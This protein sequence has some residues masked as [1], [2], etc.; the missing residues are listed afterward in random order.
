MSVFE[1][2]DHLGYACNDIH[3]A[4]ESIKKNYPVEQIS[5][6]VFDPYQNASLCY[7]HTKNGPNIE[8]ISGEAV[9]NILKKGMSLYHTCYEV[10]D[11]RSAITNV[12]NNGG[13]IIKEPYPA[14]LFNNRKV[15]FLETELGL[16]ELLETASVSNHNQTTLCIAGTFNTH[17]LFNG[18]EEVFKDLGLEFTVEEAQYNQ[19][20]QLLLD[21]SSIFY[22]NQSGY[23]I[24]YLRLEDWFRF[25]DF[26][27]SDIN[28][29]KNLLQN[30]TNDL[31]NGI[32]QL[33]STGNPL[34]LCLC[35]NT[36]ELP[37]ELQPLL[38]VFTSNIIEQLKSNKNVICN[39]E[40]LSLSP[41]NIYDRQ[42]DK[43]GH[44]PYN[45]ETNKAICLESCRTLHT[46][47]RRPYKVI[48]VDCDN[49]LWDGVCGEDGYNNIKLTAAN[50]YLQ[51]KLSILSKQGFLICLCSKNVESDVQ[52]VFEKREDFILQMSDL[53]ACKINWQRKSQNIRE[54]SNILNISLDDFIFIDDNPMEIAEVSTEL[55]QVLCLEFPRE[56]ALAHNLIKNAWC[57]DIHAN[58]DFDANRTKFYQDNAQR[59]QLKGSSDSFETFLSK[60]EIE[61][62]FSKIT[63]EDHPRISQLTQRTNQFNFTTIRRSINELEILLTD[64]SILGYKV[65]VK[66]RFGDYGLVGAVIIHNKNTNVFID[67]FLLSCRVLGKGIEHKLINEIGKV[68]IENNLQV[69]DIIFDKTQ[70]NQPA[71]DF[72]NNIPYIEKTNMDNGFSLKCDANALLLLKPAVSQVSKQESTL[73]VQ[74]YSTNNRI[75]D[76]AVVLKA[77][78]LYEPTTTNS[79]NISHELAYSLEEF[80]SFIMEIWSKFFKESLSIK[81][82][83][84]SLGGDS[85]LAI[86]VI[87]K[88]KQKYGLEISIETIFDNPRI[89][90][91]AK[92]IHTLS[93]NYKN[94]KNI[95]NIPKSTENQLSY[96]QEWLWLLDQYDNGNSWYYNMPYS[97]RLKGNINKVALEDAIKQLIMRHE[98]LRTNISYGS[99][100]YHCVLQHNINFSLEYCDAQ[101]DTEEQLKTRIDSAYRKPFNLS[102]DLLLRATLF[103][104]SDEDHVLVLVNHH[105]VSDGQSYK[106]I[107]N[108]ISEYYNAYIENRSPEL[109]DL[110]IQF[111]DYATWHRDFVNKATSK[112]LEF[113]KSYLNNLPQQEFPL[114]APRKSRNHDGCYHPLQINEKTATYLTAVA[115]QNKI[116]LFSILI[117][118][119]GILL[120]KQC[121]SQDIIITCP[122][123]GR[124]HHDS[125][126]LIGCFVNIVVFRLKIDLN[127][128]FSNNI[129]NNRDNIL[130]AL[131]NQDVPFDILLK[132]LKLPQEALDS[133][134]FQVM[135]ALQNT[136]NGM[137]NLQDIN[138]SLHQ[139]GYAA[140][141]L[142]LI[143]ELEPRDR[144]IVGGFY[145]NTNLFYESS[146]INYCNE[147]I[148][149]CEYANDFPSKPLFDFWNKTSL[150]N[151]ELSILNTP[152]NY[153]E[154][155]HNDIIEWFEAIA[156]KH[157]N[158]IALKSQLHTINYEQLDKKSNKLANYLLEKG[159]RADDIVAVKLPADI[160]SIISILAIMKLGA[161]YLPIDQSIP[162]EYFD[163][164]IQDSKCS[165][166]L[167]SEQYIADIVGEFSNYSAANLTVQK[168]N[169]A[170]IIYTSGTTG[171]PKGVKIPHVNIVQL[172]QSTQH[173]Y[174]FNCNDITILFHSIAFDFSVWEIWIALCY[175]GKLIIPT[176]QQTKSAQ[177][178]FE[179]VLQENVTV[180]NQTPTAFKQF[181]LYQENIAKVKTPHLRLVVFGGEK[182][183]PAD[184]KWFIDNNPDV[185]LYNMYGITETTVHVTIKH[186]DAKDISLQ[187]NI[188][189]PLPGR[190][191]YLLDQKGNNVTIGEIGEMYVAG[192]GLANG[193]LHLEQK[194]K[195]VFVPDLYTPQERMYK[196]GDL[197]RITNGEL[198]YLGRI[199][200]QVQLRGFR[201]ELSGIAAALNQHSGIKYSEVEV[202]NDSLAALI[203]PCRNAVLPYLSKTIEEDVNILPNG[204]PIIH[205]NKNETE[206]LYEEIFE[207]N[208]YLSEGIELDN[209]AC[210][211]D[212]GANI[213][214]FAIQAAMVSKNATVYAIEPV[215][216][217]HKVLNTNVSLY[218]LNIKTFNIGLSDTNCKKSINFYPKM[219][220]MSGSSGDHDEEK[221]LIRTHI[222][223]KLGKEYFNLNNDE[224]DEIINSYLQSNEIECD[225][226]TFDFF[227]D[228]N[229]IKKIDLLKIDVEKAE[230]QVLD[231]ISPKN[232]SI[233]QQCV[234]ELHDHEGSKNKILAI[235][236]ANNFICKVRQYHT[237]VDT[238]L[239]TIYA[240]KN[241]EFERTEHSKKHEFHYQWYSYDS[242]INDVRL[243]MKQNLPEYMQP[244]Y[245]KIV[246]QFPTTLTGKIDFS[247]FKSNEKN[248]PET[249]KDASL[250]NNEAEQVIIEVW[251]K[252]L[253]HKN[254]K[255]EDNFFDIGG[256]SLMTI[257]AYIKLRDM[258]PSDFRMIDFFS[259]PTARKLA[260]K[261]LSSKN[262]STPV[263][264]EPITTTDQVNCSDIA[265]IGYAGTFPNAENLNQYW[266]NLING[267]DCITHFSEDELLKYNVPPEYLQDSNYVKSCGKIDNIDLFDCDF[268]GVTPRE[269]SLMDPQHR[270]FLET[271]WKALES[272]GYAPEKTQQVIGI[273]AGMGNTNYLDALYKQHGLKHTYGRD[274][275]V[276]ITNHKD[277]LVNR[278]AYK[279]NLTGASININT[280]CSTSLV[281]CVKGCQSLL[282]NENDIVI[283]GGISLVLPEHYGYFH[284][285]ENVLSPDGV[286]RPFDNNA[287]G[288]VIGS[289]SG[290]VVLKK[291]SKAL[292]DGDSIKAVIKGYA[293]NND[294]NAKIG[295]TAPSVSGQSQCISKAQ[296][297]ANIT[298]KQLVYIEAHGTGTHLGD[299]IEI[300]SL[301]QVFEKDNLPANHCAIGSVK[302]NIGHADS[303]S[304]IAGLL[305]T[306]LMLEKKQIPPSIHFESANEQI[307]FST[308]PFYVNKEVMKLPG[309]TDIYAGVSSFGVG[310]ANAH[311]VLTAAPAEVNYKLKHDEHL[312]IISSKNKD[313]LDVMCNQILTHL[314]ANQSKVADIAFSLQLGR[315]DFEYRAAYLATSDN[316]IIKIH[317]DE[318]YTNSLQQL[319]KSWL[320][321]NN[322]DWSMIHQC[323]KHKRIELPHHPLNKK[324]YWYTDLSFQMNEVKN[325]IQQT[326]TQIAEKLLGSPITSVHNDFFAMGG[327]SL[328]ALSFIEKI[329]QFLKVNL[330]LDEFFS[331]KTINNIVNTIKSKT[332]TNS[333]D[334]KLLKKSHSSKSIILI[335]TLGG[336]LYCYDHLIKSLNDYNIYGISNESNLYSDLETMESLASEYINI[337]KTHI[338][339]PYIILGW[340]FGGT[341]AHEIAKQLLAQNIK[342]EHVFM[343]DSWC[344]FDADFIKEES[345]L[346]HLFNE[347]NKNTNENEW[348]KQ[349]NQVIWQR[350][351]MIFDFEANPCEIP[352]TLF[353]AQDLLPEYQSMNDHSNYWQPILG[354]DLSVINIEADHMSIVNERSSLQ[355]AKHC[356]EILTKIKE[357]S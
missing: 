34:F 110:P 30:N 199:D 184:L 169:I 219:S 261:L 186:I 167:D 26:D 221:D 348:T 168:R 195:Q 60:L 142:E 118:I 58:S 101:T 310:G 178:S 263:E 353:K 299:P 309:D 325:D 43:I 185:K 233:V 18:F 338:K 211:I 191:I 98:V 336:S 11:L 272:S 324:P 202:V 187:S 138:S 85:L 264:L 131:E 290:V 316:K 75:Q 141:R 42:M 7:I 172:M 115:Q 237:L 32:K 90:D 107:N 226:E 33:A 251:G 163:A 174:K 153:T 24:I 288:T 308:T 181:C 25:F 8:L 139:D 31:L 171:I 64:Q 10:A 114:D 301:M 352:S 54:L 13:I 260:D 63:S 152:V 205:Q 71:L 95:S 214:M 66:D 311:I 15:A 243:H 151:T 294:G 156:K 182:L 123:S 344:K 57:L 81:S 150:T 99:S 194:T 342:V 262:S 225:F 158:N 59:E 155:K 193:Y 337:I 146:I 134:L 162:K 238:N 271:C 17:Q 355:I 201:I 280:A 128:S 289:G 48:V 88:I 197:A 317:Q 283:A 36:T 189:K 268:F 3:E 253:G 318:E 119:Y 246:D 76:N 12:K 351:K 356:N 276:E 254:I 130:S 19:V 241:P 255:A 145:Y 357:V 112:Q 320:N 277:Y 345:A 327:D 92:Y 148:S 295:F 273:Y 335:H 207:Q 314:H 234:I 46:L 9:K 133:S 190:T 220:V 120:A 210:V 218:D 87:S 215:A 161:T 65:S 212:V 267:T 78:G 305:K 270:I 69:V 127:D 86:Q 37:K 104:L 252:L 223:A 287:N 180:L 354:D 113:W 259:Y 228:R 129:A 333:T 106:I 249:L 188:G 132:N 293:V 306:I 16:I 56:E 244:Q 102:K 269:A 236:K 230:L 204:L 343:I 198:E 245:Y 44:I 137:L 350:S 67:T 45:Q 5:S 14:P 6:V 340:S 124:R 282:I 323:C 229:F 84:F 68:I 274:L 297:M 147:Y 121:N 28:D 4:L 285:S 40:L 328:A 179:I 256:N 279:L 286:C 284:Q 200:K 122:V 247:V 302:G 55:P 319:A 339:P 108:E 94:H 109:S 47:I 213:G 52:V 257:Q 72:I 23:N 62:S 79:N 140:A 313:D 83:F 111:M 216:D 329:H 135:F 149:L 240:S 53:A 91:L 266:Q 349:W 39:T 170:Y 196:T 300:A 192:A 70:K 176:R 165:M 51:K 126:P 346:K 227:I 22:K 222:K 331:A 334:F 77:I 232:W 217:I 278:I 250:D 125:A 242:Y 281:A 307:D 296:K 265:V 93:S 136:N 203:I 29:Y 322:I 154:S 27:K 298:P 143:L 116:S 208:Q 248:I 117:S 321:G 326:V 258:L 183:I 173:E 231:G 315:R 80:Q 35:P 159:V 330:T 209:D 61:M 291:L 304:G 38:E 144:K 96:T 2:I 341:L 347:R 235:L 239:F 89:Q 73:N 160:Y 275:I 303:A 41:E 332:S 175:G 206:F 50:I 312:L 103:K 49:T 97:V 224:L 1:N 157:P 82:D 100:N 21:T 164:I 74:N 105:I 177:D 166:I 20:L 292:Q